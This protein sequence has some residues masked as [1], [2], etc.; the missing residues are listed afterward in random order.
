MT[1]FLEHHLHAALA[2]FRAGSEGAFQGTDP[3]DHQFFAIGLRGVVGVVAVIRIV[4][5]LDLA[6]QVRRAHLSVVVAGLAGGEDE[7]QRNGHC[8]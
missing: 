6:L 2:V 4:V 1:E 8:P 7:R 5:L 3:A